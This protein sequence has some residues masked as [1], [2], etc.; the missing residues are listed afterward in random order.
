MILMSH[1]QFKQAASWTFVLA[2]VLGL[3]SLPVGAQETSPTPGLNPLVSKDNPALRGGGSQSSTATASPG[4]SPNID[5]AEIVRLTNAAA[6]VID[7]IQSGENDLH[8]RLG[9]FEKPS[10]LDP[11]SYASKD[12]VA[13]WEGTLQQLKAQHDRVSQ[14]YSDLGKDLDTVLQSTGSSPAITAGFRKYIVDGFPWPTIEKKK[15][16][17]S[18]YI[19]EHQKLLAFYQKNWGSWTTGKTPENP[20]FNSASTTAAY[21]KLRGEILATGDQLEKTYKEMSE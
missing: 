11:T 12:E 9:Y 15:G 5:R 10:R 4:Q 6:K 19:D 3:S 13:Q 2:T 14:M 21:K 16:L 17:I 7:R 1:F 20:V 18:D 8:S